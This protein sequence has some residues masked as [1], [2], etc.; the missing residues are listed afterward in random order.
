[1]MT[2][3]TSTMTLALSDSTSG[4]SRVAWSEAEATRVEHKRPSIPSM[5]TS[6]LRF[7]RP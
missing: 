1:M 3:S 6:H 7:R 5:F 2:A 4:R